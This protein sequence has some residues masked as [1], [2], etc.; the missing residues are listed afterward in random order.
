MSLRQLCRYKKQ[1][2]ENERG[3]NARDIRGRSVINR[4]VESNRRPRRLGVSRRANKIDRFAS[5]PSL[6]LF[7]SLSNE[8][9]AN[10]NIPR[11]S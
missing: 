6:S 4:R 9:Q 7:L 11:D 8:Q 5:L 3:E 1:R 10:K 2:G